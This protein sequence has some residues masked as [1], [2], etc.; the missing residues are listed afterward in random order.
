LTTTT[1]K[2]AELN[3]RL[4]SK[5]KEWS[6]KQKVWE[7]DRTKLEATI[8]ETE[9][10]GNAALVNQRNTMLAEHQQAMDALKDDLEHVHQSTLQR[11]TYV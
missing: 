4:S 6:S 8:K 3:E 10:R 7:T 5:Q 2:F 11:K 9:E 1:A